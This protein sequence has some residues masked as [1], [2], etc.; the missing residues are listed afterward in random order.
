LLRHWVMFTSIL[1]ILHQFILKLG[2][3]KR[4]SNKSISVQ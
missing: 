1:I 2:A 4:K 3:G